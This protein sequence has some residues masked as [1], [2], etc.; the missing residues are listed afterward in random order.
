MKAKE[1]N[2]IIFLGTGSGKTFV[3]T[4]MIKDYMPGILGDDKKTVFLVNSVP[5]VTQQA[6]FIERNTTLRV[7]SFC[8]ADN[9]DF[10]TRSNWQDAIDC[11][12]VMVM[13][14]QVFLDLL[15]KAYFP[16]HRVNLLIVDECHHTIKNS[17]YSQIFK[18]FYHPLK[19]ARPSVSSSSY[20]TLDRS[21]KINVSRMSPASWL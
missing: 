17:A 6:K 4:M 13:V 21:G 15:T 18:Q 9:V 1:Q 7:R 5:L 19:E 12:D 11:V 10:W 2:A 16:L 8:G 3:A 20:I 14:H